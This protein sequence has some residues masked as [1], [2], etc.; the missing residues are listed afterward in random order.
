MNSTGTRVLRKIAGCSTLLPCFVEST[1]TSNIYYIAGFIDEGLKLAIWQIKKN[2]S[3]I[4]A[5]PIIVIVPRYCNNKFLI[6]IIVT[7]ETFSNDSIPNTLVDVIA[8]HN[9]VLHYGHGRTTREHEI[10][11]N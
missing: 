9:T 10:R 6:G 3:Q 7:N 1:G 8:P 11:Q 2:H 5:A 4:L